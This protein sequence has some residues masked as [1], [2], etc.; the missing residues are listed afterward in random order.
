MPVLYLS[1]IIL[2]LLIAVYVYRARTPQAKVAKLRSQYRH[3]LRLQPEEA[4]QI[5]ER[6]LNRVRQKFPN[7]TEQWYLEK[8]LYDLHRDRH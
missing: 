2:S 6:Q 4:D 8:I 1:I 7:H 3:E 5:L